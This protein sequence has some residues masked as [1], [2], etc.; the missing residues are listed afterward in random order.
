MVVIR[1]VIYRIDEFS[2]LAS[3]NGVSSYMVSQM[4]KGVKHEVYTLTLQGTEHAILDYC[5]CDGNNRAVNIVELD[6]N[7]IR[8][9]FLHFTGLGGVPIGVVHVEEV[10]E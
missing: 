3:M 5:L 4:L 6:R 7:I 1:K 2:K 9:C 8:E 10:K